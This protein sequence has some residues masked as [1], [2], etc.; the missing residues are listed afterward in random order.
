MAR[1]ELVRIG[2]GLAENPPEIV[3]MVCPNCP[4]CGE[5]FDILG[6]YRLI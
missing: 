6:L 5:I 4:N 2:A 3:M 1:G